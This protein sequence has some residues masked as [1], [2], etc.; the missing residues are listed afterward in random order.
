M[1]GFVTAPPAHRRD[2][3]TKLSA[4]APCYNEAAVLVEFHRR[5]SAACG[6]VT[7]DYEIVLVND[8]SSDGSWPLLL[9]LAAEDPHVVAINLSR[10]H[11]HQLALTAGLA[12]CRGER[13]L[14]IDADLQDPPELL[15]E[16]MALCDRGADIVYGKR[17]SRAGESIFKRLTAFLFYRLLNLFT[18]QHIPEDTGDFRLITRRVLDVLNSMPENHRFI[19]GM[20]S[21]VGFR[22]VPFLYDRSP[23][24]AG[25]T[26]YK[27]R[28]M[29]RFALDAVTS[30]SVRPLRLAFYAGG[31]FCVLS[32]L[33]L[34]YSIAAYFV[35]KTIR[36]WTSLM[37][38]MLFF[39]AA[40]FLVLGLIGEYVGR[41]YMET[42]HRPLFIV[43]DIVV[44]GRPV[45]HSAAPDSG[46]QA[47]YE[48]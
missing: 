29:L 42:K 1:K 19:R 35:D 27:L 17:R 20:I 37:A 44:G 2:A 7:D 31:A 25:E 3:T 38:V 30:F 5:M 24:F 36:G 26:K 12:Y 18:D 15:S 10:N 22:Q 32:I 23:R 41:L 14:I 28:K 48:R 13:I 47:G 34:A 43:A 11:G 46:I 6:T 16:M 8:G 33:L 45:S 9:S 40:Q 21:W 4:V 39:L